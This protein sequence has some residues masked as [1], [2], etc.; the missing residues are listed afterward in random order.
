MNF[1]TKKPDASTSGY[2]T[3]G[4]KSNTDSKEIISQSVTYPCTEL[5]K[6]LD[7]SRVTDIST[8][9][10]SL[11]S[12]S[13]NG[14]VNITCIH[15]RNEKPIE[16]RTFNL[17]NETGVA[18]CVEYIIHMNSADFNIYFTV[19]ELVVAVSNKPNKSDIKN[20]TIAHL[21]IDPDSTN[22]KESKQDLLDS[23]PSL[24]TQY[25]PTWIIW[26]GNGL[27]LFWFHTMPLSIDAG[28]SINKNLIVV[29][30]GDK[31]THNADR[32]MRVAGTMN[33]PSPT[34]IAKGYS[35]VP[36]KSKLIHIDESAYYDQSL[37]PNIQAFEKVHPE[38]SSVSILRELTVEKEDPNVLKKVMMA[39]LAKDISLLGFWQY[40]VIPS[41]GHSERFMSLLN[42]LAFY[43]QGDATL[44]MQ[45]LQESPFG[46]SDWFQ[47]RLQRHDNR[48]DI[49]IHKAITSQQNF[50]SLNYSTQNA[51]TNDLSH[52][53]LAK[54]LGERFFY[55]NTRYVAKYGS[56]FIWDDVRWVL[57]EKC[58][59]LSRISQFLRAKSQELLA[60]AENEKDSMSEVDFDKLMRWV[61]AESK[62]LK[63]APSRMHVE[64]IIKTDPKCTVSP[65]VF[66]S[67]L[68]TLGTPTGTI[69]LKT[70]MMMPPSQDDYITKSTSCE[71]VAGLP[72]KWLK[73]LNTI[74]D[75]DQEMI[76]FIQVLFGY[77]LTG[78]TVEEKLFFFYGTG[79]NGKSKLLEILYYILGDYAKRAPASLL[80]EQR[81]EQHP[82]GMAGLEGSRGVF[83]SETPNGKTWADQVIKDLTGGDTI[84]ARRMRQD[85][86]EFTPQFKL[87]IAG[88]HQPRLKNVDE[89]VVRRMVMIPFN[90]TIPPEQ[91]DTQLGEKLKAEAGQILGWCVEGAV[92]YFKNG[93][94]IPESVTN[95]SRE[96]IKNED[97]IGE[98]IDSNMEQDA[99]NCEVRAIFELY[100]LWITSQGYNYP[101]TERQ[102][103]KEFKDRG[104]SIKRSNSVYY[105]HNMKRKF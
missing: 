41:D 76:S 8:H 59:H 93:L 56:W 63:S 78:L 35:T 74:F 64:S 104:Y 25:K 79:A 55:Q 87:L 33:H 98:F 95:A 71:L 43:S 102:L 60:W 89:S 45:W 20:I 7:S 21:D 39:C 75:G 100:K 50:Y 70:G 24:I 2:K 32:I 77:T 96:Y 105:I 73:F 46:K 85:F 52:S 4:G 97:I 26:S 91:R 61:R 66:D 1:P 51:N 54:D 34:K 31:G 84:T 19:N 47:D 18:A 36:V 81:N 10:V 40:Q 5:Y 86:F 28:E 62:T 30:G 17:K 13:S 15:P 48:V 92:E 82:T 80:L 27:Q 16:N 67:N 53:D 42:F 29:F 65:N 83:A 14:L 37:F 99:G 57:D 90:V 38:V 68:R 101:I 44:M 22:L 58:L 3:D 11:A 88:N 6:S 94:Q 12:T 49:E 9:V 23:V 103:R 69:D 72:E